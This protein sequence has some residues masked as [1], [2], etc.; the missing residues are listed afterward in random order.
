MRRIDLNAPELTYTG[1]DPAGFRSGMYRVGPLVGAGDS[2]ATLYEL[3]PGESVCPYHYEY[4]E[5]EWVLVLAGQATVRTPEGSEQLA[6]NQLVFFPKGPGGAHEIRNDTGETVRVLMWSTV[7][8]PTATAYPDSNKVGV[9]TGEG[10]E[11]LIVERTS[12][13][14]YFHGEGDQR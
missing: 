3:P 8:L 14:D 1:D 2:G 6:A 4:G 11:D 7:V 9:W 10:S 12:A 5:E 13:V